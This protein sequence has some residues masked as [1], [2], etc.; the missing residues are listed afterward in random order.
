MLREIVVFM[1]SFGVFQGNGSA[2]AY[3]FF[4]GVMVVSQLVL[5]PVWPFAVFAGFQFGFWPGVATLVVGK[6]LSAF[7]NFSLSRSILRA[8]IQRLIGGHVLFESLNETLQQDGLKMAFL[9]RLCPVPFALGN[10][11][12][13]LSSVSLKNFLLATLLALLAPTLVFAG[14]GVSLR[15]SVALAG[16]DGNAMP[17]S[18][19]RTALALGGGVAFAL[20][21]HR[22]S[23]IAL[24]KVNEKRVAASVAPKV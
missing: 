8:W 6:M 23:K 17:E 24:V 10:Y 20:V 11:A 19:W 21:T 18:P 7:L 22:V 1:Q 2:L 5:L 3:G 12:Y 9:L 4:L 15:A 14:I 16:L 13:G